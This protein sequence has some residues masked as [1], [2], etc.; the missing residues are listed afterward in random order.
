MIMG[1][2]AVP[3]GFRDVCMDELVSDV[4]L[5]RAAKEHMNQIA[6]VGGYLNRVGQY[7]ER[8]E[9]YGYDN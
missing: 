5:W 7:V 4:A 8:R 3:E 6:V 1:G 9:D 2:Y